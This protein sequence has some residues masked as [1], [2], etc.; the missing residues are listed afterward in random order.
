MKL[1]FVA[2][3]SVGLGTGS[4]KCVKGVQDTAGGKGKMSCVGGFGNPHYF[5]CEKPAAAVQYLLYT[6]A[7]LLCNTIRL[8]PAAQMA[9][10]L[11]LP[12]RHHS[13]VA[14][15]SLVPLT[16]PPR[17]PQLLRHGFTAPT[18]IQAQA[19]PIAF[20]GRDLVAIASTG[21]GKTAGFLLPA[22]LHIKQQQALLQQ[23]QGSSGMGQQQQQ[24]GRGG[25]SW[26]KWN[27]PGAWGQMQPPVAL[28]LAPTRELA[29]Q[30]QQEAER[31]AGNGIITA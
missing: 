23:Q 5:C 20:E 13:P 2:E 19:W 4:V 22:F 26:S 18:F 3:G 12:V 6:V 10:V 21:S 24:R 15:L 29:Q 11:P 14:L 28:V 25:R 1:C 17:P 8:L 27:Q 9:A 30:T 7:W 16:S 31:L